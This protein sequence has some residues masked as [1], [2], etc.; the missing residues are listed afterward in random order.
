MTEN[1]R[2]QTAPTV[3]SN[4]LL[5]P[6][7]RA[8]ITVVFAN[9]FIDALQVRTKNEGSRQCV[10]FLENVRIFNCQFILKG[11]AIGPPKVLNHVQRLG[12]P[13]ALQLGFIVEA[14]GI[15]DERFSLPM[16][17][18]VTQPAGIR[19]DS[20]RAAIRRDDTEGSRIFVK[21]C[22]VV[23]ALEDL[24]LIGHAPR[25]RWHERHAV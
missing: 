20:V 19:I 12:V 8:V 14:D 11:I 23:Q 10:W 7:Q 15:D 22:H 21:N 4:L 17:Y 5:R 2:S 18:R 16:S 6:E 24:E 1:A 13:E 25:L 3:V 9:E